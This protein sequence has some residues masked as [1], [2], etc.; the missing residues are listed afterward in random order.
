MYQSLRTKN[1]VCTYNHDYTKE[2]TDVERGVIPIHRLLLTSDMC[3][4][5]SKIYYVGQSWINRLVPN[6]KIAQSLVI[7]ILQSHFDEVFCTTESSAWMLLALKALKL[8]RLD[9]TVVNIALL[10]P[11]YRTAFI[12]VILRVLLKAANLVIS[13]ASF[14]LP[15]LEKHF[16][17]K[18]SKLE[19][20][21][22]IVDDKFIQRHRVLVS[23][24]F[25]LSVG[26]NT[27]R[28]FNTL[29][30]GVGSNRRLVICTDDYNKAVILRCASYNPEFHTIRSA[31]PYKELLSLY[32]RCRVFI[33][34][35]HDVEFSSG[36][37]VLQEAMR[38]AP[39]VIVTNVPI[40]A[41]YV[42]D[43]YKR[44]RLDLIPAEDS[45]AISE[46]LSNEGI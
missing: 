1:I 23:E 38:L 11:T 44:C 5:Q 29:V 25:I 2:F 10:R 36:Q 37:T 21:K 39:W 34:C 16:C 42:S 46:L 13:Y 31:V 40:I 41:D 33:S 22:F 32:S 8:H 26:T 6:W 14:Q 27:G 30:S 28:D 3:E 19:F 12:M 20:R 15:L 35:L 24:D 17:I 7:C 18:R 4:S 45:N 43:A 9:I